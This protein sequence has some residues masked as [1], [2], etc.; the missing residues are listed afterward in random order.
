M[1]TTDSRPI[2][3]TGHAMV[4]HPRGVGILGGLAQEEVP[5]GDM[6][7]LHMYSLC[8]STP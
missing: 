5:L 1:K 2:A 7:V 6:H 8:S 3:R 4:P